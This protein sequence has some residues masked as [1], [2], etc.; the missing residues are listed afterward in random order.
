MKKK[1][2]NEPRTSGTNDR[3]LNEM[4]E[5]QVEEGMEKR[6]LEMNLVLLGPVTEDFQPGVCMQENN[7]TTEE[8]WIPKGG[9]EVWDLNS[10]TKNSVVMLHFTTVVELLVE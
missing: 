4:E 5:Q 2:W 9:E 8:S 7:Y 1:S 6:Y 10:K 3:E